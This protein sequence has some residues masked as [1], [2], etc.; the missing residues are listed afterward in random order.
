MTFV[1]KDKKNHK[2]YEAKIILS[3][4]PDRSEEVKGRIIVK[5]DYWQTFYTTF[6]EFYEENEVIGFLG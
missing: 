6:E 3:E 5:T 2:L 1:I 4:G